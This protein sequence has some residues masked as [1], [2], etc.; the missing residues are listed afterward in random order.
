MQQQLIFHLR[1][2]SLLEVMYIL[3]WV[4]TE[5]FPVQAPPPDARPAVMS[6]TSKGVERKSTK[7]VP[8]RTGGKQRPKSHSGKRKTVGEWMAELER[9]KGGIHAEIKLE[10]QGKA[11]AMKQE[12]EEGAC[13]D[14]GRDHPRVS[15][16]HD[17]IALLGRLQQENSTLKASMEQKQDEYAKLRAAHGDLMAENKALQAAN[18]HLSDIGQQLHLDLEWATGS[19]NSRGEA[20][21]LLRRKYSRSALD[22]EAMP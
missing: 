9:M 15:V 1:Y 6:K 12:V 2:Q 5:S 19:R 11:Q 22:I 8:Q 16:D 14:E 17:T 20:P 4:Q 21:T 3:A 18:R 10:V 7:T 13:A